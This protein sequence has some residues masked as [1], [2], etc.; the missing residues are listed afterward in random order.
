MH[1]ADA[2]IKV[3]STRVRRKERCY[4]KQKPGTKLFSILSNNCTKHFIHVL[5]PFITTF[6]PLIHKQ[7]A[8]A[9]MLRQL[10]APIEQIL[11]L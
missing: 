7:H 5:Q 11:L 8:A 3:K 9:V 4:K 10:C 2:A 6:T 1:I